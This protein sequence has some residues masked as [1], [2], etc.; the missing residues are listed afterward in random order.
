MPSGGE[1]TPLKREVTQ[2]A[3]QGPASSSSPSSVFRSYLSA[4]GGSEGIARGAGQGGGGSGGGTGGG[5][6]SRS[7]VVKTARGVGNFL[8]LVGAVGLG[9][10]LREI[11]LTQLVG[12]GATE[13]A[14]ALLDNLV[15]PASTLDEA[16]VRAA[17][18]DLNDELLGNAETYEDVEQALMDSLDRRGLARIIG[19]FFGHYIF[20]R[21]CRDFY[22]RLVKSVGSS[23]AAGT[24]NEIKDYIDSSLRAWVVNLD[25]TR[26]DWRG[27][28]GEQITGQILSETVTIF[29]VA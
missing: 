2:Y 20:E 21:F 17:L 19:S 25:I 10:A 8:G 5:G 23:R 27:S 15:G 6:G 4:I 26:I 14:S 9:E 12:Q 22:E 28:E 18:A 24:L 13:I 1:W 16:A 29:G 7:P 11:G 3:K